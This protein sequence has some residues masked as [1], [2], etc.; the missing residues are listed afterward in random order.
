MVIGGTS[1][2]APLMAGLIALIKEQK[3]KP[4]GF[5]HPALY[6]NPAVCRDITTSDNKT[7]KNKTGYNAGTDWDPCTGWGVLFKL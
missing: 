2:V 6:A 7:M 5:I 1:A 4:A 3:K